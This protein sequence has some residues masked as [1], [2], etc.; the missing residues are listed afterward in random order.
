MWA[1]TVCARA[2]AGAAATRGGGDGDG[3]AVSGDD[4]GTS[5]AVTNQLGQCRLNR[6]CVRGLNHG[7]LGGRCAF[8]WELPP[9][10]VAAGAS[11]ADAT[12]TATMRRSLI[13]SSLT[14]SRR[15]PL[16]LLARS[17]AR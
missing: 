1:R 10:P 7:G 8:A 5:T 14:F 11:A 9:P 16:P 3:A 12:A 17:M 13:T 4:G 15:L 2:A 6:L